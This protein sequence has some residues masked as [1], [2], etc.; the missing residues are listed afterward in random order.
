MVKPCHKSLSPY[1]LLPLHRSKRPNFFSLKLKNQYHPHHD[2]AMPP[3]P[4]LILALYH[5]I[6]FITI[7]LYLGASEVVAAQQQVQRRGACKVFLT[8]NLTGNAFLLQVARFSA[9]SC[10]SDQES[11]LKEASN[12]SC[13]AC[14]QLL[15]PQI[16]RHVLLHV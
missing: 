2:E 11:P 9:S 1:S 16:L 3:L 5:L 14:W 4:F 13:M 10:W 12:P 6:A 15:L 8:G 7:R